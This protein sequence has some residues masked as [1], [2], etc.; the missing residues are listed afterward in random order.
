MDTLPIVS[1]TPQLK[2]RSH[3]KKIEVKIPELDLPEKL[4]VLTIDDER[5]TIPSAIKARLR[6]ALVGSILF[7]LA[8]G[9]KIHLENG[10]LVV[11]DPGAFG[12]PWFDEIL[13]IIASEQKSRK[14]SYWLNSI[15]KKGIVDKLAERLAERKVITIEKKH[16][17][18]IIPYEAFPTINASAKYWGKQQLRSIALASEKAD[19]YDIA[20]L[21]LLK[22]CR[23]LSLVFTRDERKPVV[24]KIK[25]MFHDEVI[26]ENNSKLLA[27]IKAL[28]EAVAALVST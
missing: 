23:L 20:L 2:P 25:A 4:F 26:G 11:N 14:I 21:N 8:L 5:H 22:E 9:N 13:S 19:L 1:E 16:Y 17:L 6:Y 10:R 15:D 18:W 12:E 24:K 27:D 7:E 3:K 28:S